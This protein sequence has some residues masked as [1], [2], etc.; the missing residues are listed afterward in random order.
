MNPIPEDKSCKECSELLPCYCLT[1][2]II[3]YWGYVVK[4]CRKI[5]I[6]N[7][8]VIDQDVTCILSV[9]QGQQLAPVWVEELK[10]NEEDRYLFLSK[11][12]KKDIA[13]TNKL[14]MQGIDLAEYDLLTGHLKE[15]ESWVECQV[16]ITKPSYEFLKVFF[17]G[18]RMLPTEQEG[19]ALFAMVLFFFPNR[20]LELVFNYLCCGQVTKHDRNHIGE[21]IRNYEQFIKKLKPDFQE[22]FLADLSTGFW[23]LTGVYIGEWL[24]KVLDNARHIEEKKGEKNKGKRE[25][26][27]LESLKAACNRNCDELE[28]RSSRFKKI[29]A[30]CYHDSC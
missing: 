2:L 9:F 7:I 8:F 18:V 20:T 11:I 26:F 19:K 5:D 10:K 6:E 28:R 25:N 17:E 23:Q 15:A 24:K 13:E 16:T 1:G 12:C 4:N 30:I 22:H 29:K 27:Y 3:N 21:F 14:Y